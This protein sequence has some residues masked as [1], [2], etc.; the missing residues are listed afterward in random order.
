MGQ[1]VSCTCVYIQEIVSR[2][3]NYQRQLT[4]VSWHHS[5][6]A[7]LFLLHQ[8]IMYQSTV[9]KLYVNLQKNI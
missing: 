3:Q 1:C 4:D 2:Q 8:D 6:T 9:S 7:D 5:T